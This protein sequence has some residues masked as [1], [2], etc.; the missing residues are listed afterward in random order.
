MLEKS[1]YVLS[2]YSR[3]RNCQE[4]AWVPRKA[5]SIQDGY[6]ATDPIHPISNVSTLKFR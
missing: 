4:M 3:D 6:V 2:V 5:V 1:K